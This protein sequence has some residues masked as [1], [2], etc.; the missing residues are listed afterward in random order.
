L[1]QVCDKL[2]GKLPNSCDHELLDCGESNDTEFSDQEGD[3]LCLTLEIS[4]VGECTYMTE[5]DFL[6]DDMDSCIGH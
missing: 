4:D 3:G 6:W 5:T 2:V 1:R